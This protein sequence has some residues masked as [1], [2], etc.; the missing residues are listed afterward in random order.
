MHNHHVHMTRE[1]CDKLF[2]EGYE[3][4][5]KNYLTKHVYACQETIT[6]AGP[7]GEIHNVRVLGPLR[8]YNQVELLRADC[9]KLGVQAPI[10][11]S[12][13]LDGAATLRLIGPKGE[14]EAPC[15]IIALRHIHLGTKLG[16]QLGVKD[17]DFVDVAIG[18]ERSLIF[19]KVLIR[20]FGG[21][22]SIM[23][24]DSEEGNAA[25]VSNNALGEILIWPEPAT[26]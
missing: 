16:A 18:G 11:D 14:M 5:L 17:K 10:R 21:E 2:G 8:E 4:T 1:M 22:D 20:T 25:G 26:V 24:L 19:R 23:H 6:V 3:L 15:G 13:H 12:G 9:F 7:K